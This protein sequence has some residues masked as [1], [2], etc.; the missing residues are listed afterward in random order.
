MKKIIFNL[1]VI[2]LI[3]V[4]SCGPTKITRTINTYEEL[5][6]G[7]EKTV[8][9]SVGLPTIKPM[10]GTNVTQT[11]GTT[12][13]S[14]LPSQFTIVSERLSKEEVV[15]AD[16]NQP[17]YDI[18]L[19]TTVD[20]YKPVPVDATKQFLFTV[21]VTNNGNQPFR[22]SDVLVTKQRGGESGT[23]WSAD[24]F[25]KEW[26][27]K[28]LATKS[29]R[30]YHIDGVDPKSLKDG[31]IFYFKIDGM[32]TA[33][34]KAGNI[35]ERKTFEW[36][37]QCSV[38]EVKKESK[39]VTEYIAKPIETEKC[40]KCDAS[41]FIGEPKVCPTCKGTG[42]VSLL[43]LT[44]NC[45]T[46]KGTGKVR[47]PCDICHGLGIISLPKSQPRPVKS[48]VVLNGWHVRI[49]TN[50]SAASVQLI[51]PETGEYVVQ[52]NTSPL[53]VQWLC[54]DGGGCPI[55]VESMGKRVKVI[56]VD[57]S[58]KESAAI[59]IDFNGVTPIVKGG[60]IVE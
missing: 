25:S 44:V 42:K 46:C 10:R 3:V 59:S 29:S 27:E 49:T 16:P 34:D 60:R 53:T 36:W 6:K 31:D 51:D 50:P 12:T 32:P 55:I 5:E 17:D 18:F 58:G 38:E 7:G 15:Y 28:M 22:L 40:K 41:G 13:V 39:E 33:F 52:K 23:D 54:K 9:L 45:S 20:E 21:K 56:P 47:E 2:L 8:T 48:S 1:F 26:N 30:D 57:P 19:K 43:G 11:Q 37:F 24:G 4:S 35:A 14:F